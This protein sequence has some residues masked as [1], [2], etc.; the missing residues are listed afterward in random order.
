MLTSN[1]VRSTGKWSASK[2][3]GKGEISPTSHPLG[4]H[5]APVAV[6]NLAYRCGR[7]KKSDFPHEST[8]DQWFD[9][10]QYESYRQLGEYVGKCLFGHLTANATIDEIVTAAGGGAA[11]QTVPVEESAFAGAA[12]PI[13]RPVDPASPARSTIM[14]RRPPKPWFRR[15]GSPRLGSRSSS[16]RR[17]RTKPA[18]A[19]LPRQ[20]SEIT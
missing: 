6:R 5:P 17:A 11:A 19:E 14:H 8:A 1:V 18:P 13:G 15:P 20:C 9:E 2:C 3:R 7:P 4:P 10:T 16:R 12:A